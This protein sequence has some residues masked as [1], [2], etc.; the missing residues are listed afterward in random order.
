[1]NVVICPTDFVQKEAVEGEDAL[2]QRAVRD[3]FDRFRE[4]WRTVRRVPDD[5]QIDFAVKVA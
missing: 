2:P 3:W 4:K 5:V 1:M